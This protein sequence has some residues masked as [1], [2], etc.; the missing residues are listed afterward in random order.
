M[1]HIV[2]CRW[3]RERS[4]RRSINEE[5]SIKLPNRAVTRK[6]PR[7]H[8]YI[9]FHPGMDGAGPETPCTTSDPIAL[10]ETER[11]GRSA[12]HCENGECPDP[13]QRLAAGLFRR[14]LQMNAGRKFFVPMAI[15]LA[16][17]V[18]ATATPPAGS[19][20]KQAPA[21]G[22]RL[23]VHTTAG[24][25]L[26]SDGMKGKV[27]LLDFMTTVC[28]SCKAAALEIQKLY[29]EL[30]PKGFQPVCIAL[31]VD[32]PAALKD[33]GRE[34]GLTFT[35]GTASRADVGA[36]LKHPTDKPFLV[37]TLV[38]LDRRG[39]VHSIDVGWRGREPLRAAIVKL[40]AR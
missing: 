26:R 9:G 38:L 30:G 3:Y 33:Y 19:Q 36:Y 39:K 12:R 29:G 40:L 17:C 21:P 24:K 6:L 7:N 35:L 4:E 13:V 27:V 11:T 37:P 31:N 22:G 10:S 34:H 14:K 18:C 28:P 8:Q 15:A 23:N 20:A 2:S 16:F 32:S 25:L 5:K 1:L